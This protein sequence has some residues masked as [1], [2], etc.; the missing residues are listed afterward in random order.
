VAKPH[1]NQGKTYKVNVEKFFIR[2]LRIKLHKQ[3]PDAQ[4]NFLLHVHDGQAF[5]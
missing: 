2:D 4:N 1:F 3:S 5:S